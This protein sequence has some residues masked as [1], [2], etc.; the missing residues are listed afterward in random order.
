MA[1]RNSFLSGSTYTHSAA[2][3]KATLKEDQTKPRKSK[4]LATL[5]SVLDEQEATQAT[6]ATQGTGKARRIPSAG[7][8]TDPIE[9]ESMWYL[10]DDER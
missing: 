1:R 7:T 2:G 3:K 10:M 6:Q 4:K 9:R 8:G 5:D